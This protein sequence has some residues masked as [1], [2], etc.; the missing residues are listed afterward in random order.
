LEQLFALG[1]SAP[2][3]LGIRPLRVVVLVVTSLGAVFLPGI[4]CNT[5]FAAMQAL[6]GEL[7]SL[8]ITRIIRRPIS[9]IAFLRTISMALA[10]RLEL[11][12]AM[13]AFQ[14]ISP[15]EW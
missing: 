8:A 15:L 13:L 4:C 10:R 9:D 12:S 2:F 14:R 11:R 5:L 3:Q 6:V 1:A 7:L